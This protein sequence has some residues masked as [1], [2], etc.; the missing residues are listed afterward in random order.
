MSGFVEQLTRAWERSDSLACVGLDPDLERFPGHRRRTL[1]DLPVQQGHH[2]R[3]RGSG[4]RVQAAVRALRRLRG[5]DQ[6]ERTI[7]YIHKKHPA[8]P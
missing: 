3:H 2:R 6:L 1:A 5:E 8:C 7:E 4:V